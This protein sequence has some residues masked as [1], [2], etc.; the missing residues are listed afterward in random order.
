MCFVRCLICSAVLFLFATSAFSDSVI[1]WFGRTESP[2]ALL[3]GTSSRSWVLESTTRYIA[4]V[5]PCAVRTTYQFYSDMHMT[6][7]ACDGNGQRITTEHTWK[8][9]SRDGSDVLI[10]IDNRVYSVLVKDDKPVRMLLR[11][12]AESKIFPTTDREFVLSP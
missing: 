1:G 3:A 7:E 6:I 2:E 11:D 10:Q 12:R 4:S 5:H 9:L 8:V